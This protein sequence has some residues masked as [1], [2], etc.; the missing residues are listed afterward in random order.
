MGGENLRAGRTGLRGNGAVTGQTAESLV[1]QML[2]DFSLTL[3]S[4]LSIAAFLLPQKA[5]HSQVSAMTLVRRS[6][7]CLQLQLHAI[8][9][10]V[11]VRTLDQRSPSLCDLERDTTIQGGLMSA[12]V[13]VSA[14][15]R[16]WGKKPWVWRQVGGLG[17]G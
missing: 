10:V 16:R 7:I 11:P 13:L 9:P 5:F 6:L 3:R 4:P 1:L 8:F 14:A 17:N 12:V 15:Q 2:T